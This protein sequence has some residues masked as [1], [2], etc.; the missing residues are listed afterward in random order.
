MDCDEACLVAQRNSRFRSALGVQEAR[1]VIPYPAPLLDRVLDLN[2]LE[3]CSR[4]ER[5]IN[6]WLDDSNTPTK[7]FPNMPATHRWILHQLA[8]YYELHSESFDQEPHRSV[9]MQRSAASQIPSVS[10]SSAARTYQQHKSTSSAPRTV[11][12]LVHFVELDLFPAVAPAD[13][14]SMLGG[15]VGR[16][17]LNWLD[18]HAHAFAVVESA[19]LATQIAEAITK[20]G[21]WRTK[22]DEDSLYAH[23]LPVGVSED[24]LCLYRKL[25]I[26]ERGT[27]E[28][29]IKERES[30]KKT[31]S[32]DGFTQVGKLRPTNNQASPVAASVAAAPLNR[33]TTLLE[34]AYD[35]ADGA[36][37]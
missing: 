14:H 37:A 23:E 12:A 3:L 16:Y 7:M 29:C 33:W 4:F 15:F 19:A 21:L 26:N 5:R 30:R 31:V 20:K 28:A 13:L 35:S 10:L 25:R 2:L 34:S 22:P 9:R 24:S 18:S 11:D 36:R 8:S 6:D 27:R 1:A 17:R 32:D